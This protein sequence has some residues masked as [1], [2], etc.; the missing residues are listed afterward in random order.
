MN[1]TF[2][3]EV[4]SSNSEFLNKFPDIRYKNNLLP[5][6]FSCVGELKD[7]LSPLQIGQLQAHDP[8]AHKNGRVQYVLDPSDDPNVSLDADTGRLYAKRS[9]DREQLQSFTVRVIAH[10]MSAHRRY[11]ATATVTVIIEDMNDNKPTFKMTNQ[12]ID[13]AE[14]I[15]V[16]TTV[17]TLEANDPDDGRNGQVR[18]ASRT[19]TRWFHLTNDGR[20]SVASK[21]DREKQKEHVLVVIASDE[22]SI[23]L[24]STATITITVTDVNDHAPRFIIPSAV[25]A[26]LRKL[27]TGE[28]QGPEGCRQTWRHSIIHRVWRRH[29]L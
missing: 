13:V 1:L 26:W 25:S 6:Q 2:D 24:T 19:G 21:L 9:F 10:D 20:L 22:G 28:E 11:S 16:P 5:F 18:F 12:R 8:D 17:T 3:R 7:R 4:W 23:P 14:D 15:K 27:G 29:D